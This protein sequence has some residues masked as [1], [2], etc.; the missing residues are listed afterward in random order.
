MVE[1]G[2]DGLLNLSQRVQGV[3]CGQ[4][5]SKSSGEEEER[6]CNNAPQDGRVPNRWPS[7]PLQ[8]SPVCLVWSG[9]QGSRPP[10]L[11][12]PLCPPPRGSGPGAQPETAHVCVLLARENELA[13]LGKKDIKA[14][15]AQHAHKQMKEHT[16]PHSHSI[17]YSHSLRL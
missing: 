11:N 3:P 8:A 10:S 2:T 12:R 5:K 13:N 16:D 15:T 1:C 17:A 9:P 6:V 14:T 7:R 4:K